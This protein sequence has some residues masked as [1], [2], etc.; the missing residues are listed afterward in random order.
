M[1]EKLDSDSPVALYYQLK[2]IIINKIKNEEWPVNSKLP[3]E[4]DL[5]EKYQISRATV[6]QAL[7]DIENEGY[8][9]R[10]QG[11]GTFVKPHKIEQKLNKFYS[12]S[13]EI[14]KMG[15]TPSTEVLEFKVIMSND[16]IMERMRLKEDTLLYWIKR[17]RLANQ[18]PFAVEDSYVPCFLCPGM[19]REHIEENGLYATMRNVFNICLDSMEETIES[20]LVTPENA[21]LLNTPN[22]SAGLY[23]RRTTYAQD[24]IVEYCKTIVNGD[25]Y[26][27]QVYLHVSE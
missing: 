5:V 17:L 3:T 15:Y 7:N 10:K 13:E 26:K 20:V 1:V 16:N 18:Q 19:T 21:A 12:F 27:Y 11:K 25:L 9:Y 24:N 22:K 8:I 23:L 14:K 4:M 2:Q 6:R